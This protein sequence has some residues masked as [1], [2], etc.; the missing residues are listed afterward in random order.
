M[1]ETSAHPRD[2]HEARL[3]ASSLRLA[4]DGRDV[5]HD[6]AVR[7]PDGGFTV[8]IGP[9]ACGKS[10]VLR[11][12]ARQ[13]RPSAGAVTLDGRD[14]DAYRPKEFARALAL[15]PQSVVPPDGISVADLIARGRF[16]HQR[17]LRQW[18]TDDERAVAHA[19]AAT[20]VDDLADRLVDELSGG[21]RQRVLLAMVL[22]QSTD[23]VLL[24]EPTTFLDLTHQIEVLELCRDLHAAGKTVV[25][26]LHD[27]DQAC[28]YATH[29]IAMRDG[30][31]VA[32]GPPGELVTAELVEEVFGLRAQVVPDPLTGTP[33][34]VPL[35]GR[36]AVA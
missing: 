10:T 4:Y 17:M 15:L 28:R 7:I 34:V 2:A 31:V 3:E 11:A 16:P 25:A 24:D 36:A 14:V 19:M 33:L 27:V 18:S 9:N 30:R 13:L 1:H 6:L 20:G 23:L 35:P 8:I 21:Q 5:V 32:E 26:V 12:L 22:A 29:L